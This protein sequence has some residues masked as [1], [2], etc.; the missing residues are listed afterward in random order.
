MPA[1]LRWVCMLWLMPTNMK[2]NRLHTNAPA[3]EMNAST[4][5]AFDS[6]AAHRF[7][8]AIA[9]VEADRLREGIGTLGEK[10]LHAVL[11][12]FYQPDLAYHEQKIG[13]YFADIAKDGEIIEIQTRD[14]YR[15][16]KKIAAFLEM[17][18][19]VRVVHP[20]PRNRKIYW[21]D[22]EGNL[23]D[24]RK[25]PKTGRPH[26]AAPELASLDSLIGKP[27]LSFTVLLLDV[28]DFRNL[29][30]W[31]RGGKRGSSRFERM[32]LAYVEEVHLSTPEDWRALL[33]VGLPSPFT[34]AE[35]NKKGGYSP[36]RGYYALRLFVEFGMIRR[37]GSKGKAF[38]YELVK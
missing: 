34:A 37:I 27:G 35:F 17:G 33:P 23:S 25:S 12:H 26:T 11:K 14:L 4:A 1:L 3:V 18:Y 8:E 32:P 9:K 16:K 29:D 38:L 19:R 36:R 2:E 21:I 10:T 5:D 31:G 30:G 15:L 24:G 13:S 7:T 20:V 6:A 22:S 28:E